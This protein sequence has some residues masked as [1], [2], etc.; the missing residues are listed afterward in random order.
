MT[1]VLKRLDTVGVTQQNITLNET[2]D[3]NCS[4]PTT[5]ALLQ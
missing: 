1:T 4:A 2:A 3:E 5:F